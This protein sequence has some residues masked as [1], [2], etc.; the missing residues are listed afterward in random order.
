[1]Q[2]ILVKINHKRMGWVSLLVCSIFL[3]G[4]CADIPVT[5]AKTATSGTDPAGNKKLLGQEGVVFLP[6]VNKASCQACSYG[7]MLMDPQPGDWIDPADVM[8]YANDVIKI[9]GLVAAGAP[10]DKVRDEWFGR[11]PGWTRIFIRGTYDQLVSIHQAAAVF[12][13]ENM[14][15]CI[16]YGPE[17]THQAGDEALDPLTWVPMAK[18]LADSVG[19]CLVYGPAVRD[20]ELMATPAGQQEPDSDSL[21]QLITSVS[22]HV[23]IWMI[24]LAKYQ[25]WVDGGHDDDGNPYTMNDFSNWVKFWVAQIK[26]GNPN[27]KVWVQL[28]IGV[29]D[30]IS[31]ACLSPQ[32][33]EY[34]VNYHDALSQAG[35]SGAF[36]APSQ[37]CQ[38]STNPLDREN[39][40]KSIDV[41]N[42][43][44]ELSCGK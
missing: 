3:F 26:N 17:S 35:I 25:T 13:M 1:M 44:I 31:K 41:F 37:P 34:L 24:Q 20:Y 14:Y 19:K 40:L 16:G 7:T 21:A 32:P 33:P 9:K 29:F 22:P 27:A 38:T 6:F 39:Y 4:S 8:I 36:V 30:P 15:E 23:D 42:Q 5:I 12:D 11:L 18:D 2:N 10:S 43:A 28:G